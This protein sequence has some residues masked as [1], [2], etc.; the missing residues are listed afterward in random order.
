MIV[1]DADDQLRGAG[2]AG[3][4]SGADAANVGRRA[5][6]AGGGVP[7]ADGALVAA[8]LGVLKAGGAYVPLDPAYPAERLA[9]MVRDSGA[10]VV[11]TTG[12]LTA[13]LPAGTPVVCVEA[14]EADEAAEAEPP[15]SGG[16]ARGTWRM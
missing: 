16:G 2:P 5:G 3:E 8:L 6:D 13:R 7:G 9:F 4:S 14:V 12:A 11:V 15:P 10:Q 1:G